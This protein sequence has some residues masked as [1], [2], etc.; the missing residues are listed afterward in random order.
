M[1]ESEGHDRVR[2]NR[3][4]RVLGAH[5]LPTHHITTHAPWQGVYLAQPAT[6]EKALKV[7]AL[8]WEVGAA[9]RQ[10]GHQHVRVGAPRHAQRQGNG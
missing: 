4:G 5:R 7:G 6:L 2:L 3:R 8:T 9:V 1:A 10:E